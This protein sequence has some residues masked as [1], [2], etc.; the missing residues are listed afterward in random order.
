[1]N[2]TVSVYGNMPPW[3][4]PFWADKLG[5]SQQVSD[6]CDIVGGMARRVRSCIDLTMPLFPEDRI[7]AEKARQYGSTEFKRAYRD[8]IL[9]PYWRALSRTV[10]ANAKGKC[11]RCGLVAMRLEVHHIHYENFGRESENDLEALCWGC[12]YQA[13][14]QR[15]HR[16]IQNYLVA[17]EEARR[18]AAKDTYLSKVLAHYG[19]DYWLAYACDPGHHDQK[20]DAWYVDARDGEVDEEF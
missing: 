17:G 9:S 4:E 7:R 2:S 12:H 13:D 19:D 14:N 5:I 11:R 15:V 10:R 6:A 16:G 20:F 18:E 3:V 8:H 1:M